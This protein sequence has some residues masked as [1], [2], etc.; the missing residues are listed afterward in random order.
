MADISGVTEWGNEIATITDAERAI[1]ETDEFQVH[2]IDGDDGIIIDV[3][4]SR[5]KNMPNIGSHGYAKND[6]GPD[7]EV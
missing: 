3:F 1:I 2:V 7:E 4:D 5:D 6:Y